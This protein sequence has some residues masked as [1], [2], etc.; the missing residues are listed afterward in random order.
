MTANRNDARGRGLSL[1]EVMAA[2]VILAVLAAVI[3]PRLG[4]HRDSA[5]RN[6]CHTQRADIELQVERWRTNTGS[7]PA[8]NLSDIG[9]DGDY[10]PGGVPT[11]PVDGTTYT[12]DTTDGTVN[13][14]DH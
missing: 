9:A 12:I 7:Y 8:A 14:H 3:V 2:A 1:L 11:C 10:F 5:Y 6:A 4:G 13:G